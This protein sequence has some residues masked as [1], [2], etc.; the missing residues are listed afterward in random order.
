MA[1]YGCPPSI[2]ELDVD[3]TKSTIKSLSTGPLTPSV[4]LT[5][6]IVWTFGLMVGVG[7]LLEV[8]VP[9][10]ARQLTLHQP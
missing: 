2:S 10:L 7:R 8:A 6:T 5:L 9:E 1:H 4:Q 3:G